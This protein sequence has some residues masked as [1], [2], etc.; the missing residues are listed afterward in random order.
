[1]SRKSM[2][3]DVAYRIYHLKN[4]WKAILFHIRQR[5]YMILNG[6]AAEL[7][8]MMLEDAENLNDFCQQND[9]TAED[10]ADFERQLSD[11]GAFAPDDQAILDDSC[12]E[13]YA[14]Q[15]SEVQN[16]HIISQLEQELAENGLYYSMHI[17]V[18][19]RCNE[20]CIH[21][22]HPFDRYDYEKE[23]TLS[24]V[25]QLIDMAYDLGVFTITLS[26]GEALLRKDIF[27]IIDYISRKGLLIVLFTNGLLLTEQNVQRLENYR[28]NLVS[29]SI[30][31]ENAEVHDRIT[32]VKGSFAQTLAGIERL[33][34]H[35][36]LFDLKCVV[37][38]ENAAHISEIG[39]FAK[40]LNNGYECLMDFTLCGKLDGDCSVMQHRVSN[41]TLKTIFYSDPQRYIGSKTDYTRTPDDHPCNAGRYGLYCDAYGDIYPCVSFRLYLCHYSE[42]PTIAENK[43]LKEWLNTRISDFTE[44]FKH[45]YCRYCMEQCAGNNLIENQDYRDSKVSHCDRAKIICE[46]FL[47]CNQ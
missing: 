28:I 29:I 14:S 42:L 40:E 31:G 47:S 34:R 37:L 43:V 2:S 22:Y 44:C 30:Y 19:H 12:V 20:K 21:C 33:K 23:L 36:I 5:N 41:H 39:E 4:G 16:K 10:V 35:H 1:M 27:E 24:E 6:L 13:P 45:D 3:D 8:R 11:F 32:T 18:T 25:K 38:A 9:L 7:L 17:D 46:W 15:E 26:G